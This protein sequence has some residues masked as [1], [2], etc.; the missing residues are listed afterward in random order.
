V[1]LS[2]IALQHVERRQ[3]SPLWNV[4]LVGFLTT[5]DRRDWRCEHVLSGG[6]PTFNSALE[7][8]QD[9]RGG[10]EDGNL[11]VWVNDKGDVCAPE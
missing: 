10:I 8:A 1:T 7:R 6:H 9:I 4:V 3:A 11:E 2:H 5:R